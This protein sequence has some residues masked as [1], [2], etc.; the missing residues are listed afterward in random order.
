MCLYV[1]LVLVCAYVRACFFARVGV[2]VLVCDC[3]CERCSYTY[4]DL[5]YP[6]IPVLYYS[7]F[8]FFL[9]VSYFNKSTGWFERDVETEVELVVRGHAHP[10]QIAKHHVPY[11]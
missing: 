1:V 5:D 6:L 9:F 2:R 8:L 7:Y 10:D 4:I 3:L 11:T